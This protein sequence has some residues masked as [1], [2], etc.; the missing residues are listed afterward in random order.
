MPRRAGPVRAR[1]LEARA[2]KAEQA[3]A[4]RAA[5]ASYRQQA[6]DA[7]ERLDALRA[8]RDSLRKQ[9]VAHGKKQREI[10]AAR[11]NAVA[12]ATALRD[13]VRRLVSEG[14]DVT[15]VTEKRSQADALMA[16]A[17][18]YDA[19][20][21]SAQA[22]SAQRQL[23]ALNY[24]LE[25]AQSEVET[26]EALAEDPFGDAA[27]TAHEALMARRRNGQDHALTLSVVERNQEEYELY[28]AGRRAREGR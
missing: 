27:R 16:V 14:A 24:P 3:E 11:A 12:R 19:A 1:A 2:A 17:H 10:G 23:D 15:L 25:H 22:A 8:E 13:E 4:R 18:D 28:L 5:I 9:I 20:P 21:W 6:N 7:R 26:F